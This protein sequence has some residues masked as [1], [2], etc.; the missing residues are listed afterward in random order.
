M[1]LGHRNFT[2]QQNK[3]YYYIKEPPVTNNVDGH[4]GIKC[5]DI[6]L[7]GLWNFQ[8]L[9]VGA[10]LFQQDNVTFDLIMENLEGAVNCSYLMG[11]MT[12]KMLEYTFQIE[13]FFVSGEIDTIGGHILKM[14][15][16]FELIPVDT[17]SN[18]YTKSL[19]NTIKQNIRSFIILSFSD[20]Y[21]FGFLQ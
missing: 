9:H 6:K 4:N 3:Y 18:E 12:S 11:P 2:S 16:N 17:E 10:D 15:I 5:G 13:Q 21:H 8:Y 20:A 14:D 7:K 1:E 19:L